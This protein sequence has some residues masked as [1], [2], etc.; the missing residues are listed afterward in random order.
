VGAPG[1]PVYARDQ[2]PLRQ[3]FSELNPNEVQEAVTSPA[4]TGQLQFETVTGT[5]SPGL[6]CGE[7]ESNGQPRSCWLVIVPRGLY[8]PNGF[9]IDPTSGSANG[10]IPSSP[11][12]ASNWAI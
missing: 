12:G 4:G 5:Q 11:L 10:F 6:G 7:K 2:Q 3:S 9:K 8:E 1:S